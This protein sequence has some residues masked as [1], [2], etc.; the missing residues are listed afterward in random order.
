MP[1]FKNNLGIGRFKE[2]SLEL[3]NSKISLE[4]Y[5]E[6]SGTSIS[7]GAWVGLHSDTDTFP[8]YILFLKKA[9]IERIFSP[10][11][12]IVCEYSQ[13]NDSIHVMDREE[14]VLT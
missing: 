10:V 5:L 12:H 13:L 7:G 2:L 8:G 6:Y 14:K 4:L 3:G 1:D 9:A 11:T